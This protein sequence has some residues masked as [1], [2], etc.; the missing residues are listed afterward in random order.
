MAKSNILPLQQYL[1][2]SNSVTLYAADLGIFSNYLQNPYPHPLQSHKFL[3]PPQTPY[4]FHI[5]THIPS[6]NIF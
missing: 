5:L 2:S 3:I 1:P 6:T 4:F